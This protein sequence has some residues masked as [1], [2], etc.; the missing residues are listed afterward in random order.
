MQHLEVCPRIDHMIDSH[1]LPCAKGSPSQV[2]LATEGQRAC[3]GQGGSQYP[4]GATPGMC[5]GVHRACSV[6]E[7]YARSDP[8]VSRTLF[9]CR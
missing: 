4:G 7:Q 8:T 9:G 1:A 5:N 3:G 2:L 6:T